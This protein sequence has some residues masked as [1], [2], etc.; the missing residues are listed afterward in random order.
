LIKIL[1][2]NP[3]TMRTNLRG[4]RP[5]MHGWS[6]MMMLRGEIVAHDHYCLPRGKTRGIRS[7]LYYSSKNYL[8]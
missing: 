2:R 8:H 1:S 4:G 5:I 7:T 3:N 6:L